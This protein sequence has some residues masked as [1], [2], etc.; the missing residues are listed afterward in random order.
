MVYGAPD[1]SRNNAPTNRNRSP[2]P[3]LGMGCVEKLFSSLAYN[4]VEW[5]C[6][7]FRSFEME[8]GRKTS[9]HHQYV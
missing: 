6:D 7:A 1:A 3:P 2:N 8:E 9:T 4:E 5:L